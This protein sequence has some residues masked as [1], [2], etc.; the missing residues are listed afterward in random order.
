MCWSFSSTQAS[1]VPNGS[2][3]VLVLSACAKA[4]CRVYVRISLPPIVQ[5]ASRPRTAGLCCASSIWAELADV[6]RFAALK[7]FVQWAH[8]MGVVSGSRTH[9]GTLPADRGASAAAAPAASPASAATSPL[10]SSVEP[11][12]RGAVVPQA[13]AGVPS[14]ATVSPSHVSAAEVTGA[15]GN[16]L[17]S[18]TAAGVVRGVGWPW[19]CSPDRTVVWGGDNP[20]GEFREPALSPHRLQLLKLR[21]GRTDGSGLLQCCRPS[22]AS[23]NKEGDEVRLLELEGFDYSDVEVGYDPPLLLEVW[24]QGDLLEVD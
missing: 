15:I 4:V 6:A 22:Q 16:P 10:A 19:W 2:S 1:L 8:R 23:C 18:E 20:V 5:L 21:V 9:A 12:V 3:S 13:A 14:P 24:V 17:P 7:T 11:P